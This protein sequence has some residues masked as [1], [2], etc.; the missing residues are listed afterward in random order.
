MPLKAVNPRTEVEYWRDAYGEDP[1]A[2]PQVATPTDIAEPQNEMGNF[3]RGLNAGV[4]QTQALGGGL[5]AAFGSVIG[6][7]AMVDSGMEIYRRNMSEADEYAGDV[8]TVEEIDS[9]SEAGQWA[10]YTLGTLVPDLAG[11]ITTGG[12]GGVIAKQA[13]KKGVKELAEKTAQESVEELLKAGVEKDAAEYVSKEIAEKKALDYSGK[14]ATMGALAGT[15]TYT[16]PTITGGSF[17]NILEE[18]GVEAPLTALG[19]GVVGAGLEAAPFMKAFTSVFPSGSLK[20]FKEFVAGDIADSPKWVTQALKDIVQVQGA[21]GGTEA[22]QFLLE[23]SAVTFV[24][25]NYTNDEA[26]EYLDFLSNER[27]RSGLINST[28]AGLLMGTA[29][30][31]GTAGIKT[32]KGQYKSEQSQQAK[33]FRTENINNENLRS[34]VVSVFERYADAD[35]KGEQAL[36]QPTQAD[37]DA[38]NANE[39]LTPEQRQEAGLSELADI[40]VQESVQPV[41]EETPVADP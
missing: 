30:G 18:T 23:E 38:L 24:N 35:A 17:A 6:S 40:D 7:E 37:T 27:K 36:P 14:V 26:K 25:N 39:P 33:D 9:V 29:T 32:A 21:E 19:V 20:K 5:K 34:E 28:A 10:A 1:T 31:V 13:V 12:V 2:P 11:A 15:G 41:V 22:L 8:M 16:A 4:N 3:S